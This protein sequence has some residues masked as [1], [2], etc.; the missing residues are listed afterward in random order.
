MLALR[1]QEGCRCQA[2]WRT[3]MATAQRALPDVFHRFVAH[4]GLMCRSKVQGG[5]VAKRQGTQEAVAQA[6]SRKAQLSRFP[7]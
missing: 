3:F 5:R 6:R 1:A 7:L 2:A 4:S